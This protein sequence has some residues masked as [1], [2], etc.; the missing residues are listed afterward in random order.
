MPADK[1]I[2]LQPVLVAH[3]DHA[4]EPRLNC[5][6]AAGLPDLRDG[7]V[8]LICVCTCIYTYIFTVPML[9]AFPTCG[10]AKCV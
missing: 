2:L 8:C 4:T 7:K 6:D 10:S 5:T 9:L 1:H 3:T